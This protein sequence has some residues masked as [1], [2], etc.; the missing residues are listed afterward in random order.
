MSKIDE[1]KALGVNIEEALD[2]FMGNGALY[3]KMLNKL[4]AAVND[5]QVL[6][7]FE[8][9]DHKTALEN[10]HALKGVTGNLSITPLYKGYTEIV[11]ELRLKIPIR[12]EKFWR[13]FFPFKSR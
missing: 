13:I 10:A 8:A 1:L 9:G 2:R 7:F 12:R 4:T 5:V 11:D 6:P 3:E